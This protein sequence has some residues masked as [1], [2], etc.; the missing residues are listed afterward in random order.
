[1]LSDDSILVLTTREKSWWWSMQEVIPAVERIWTGIGQSGRENVR[2]LCVPL[3]PGIEQDLQT[4]ASQLKRI[5]I[6]A[7]TPETVKIAL[8]LRLQMKVDAPMIIYIFGDSTEGFHAFGALTDVLTEEDMF[9]VS[10][11]AEAAA[12]RCSFPNAEVSVIPIPLVDRFKMNGGDR[13]T[14]LKDARLAYVGRVSEQKNLHTLLFALWILHT[15]HG[16]LPKIT[17]E[18]YGGEDN[19]GS[20]NMGLK[21]P[22]YGMYLQGLTELLGLDRMVTWHG[23][24]SR[25]WLFDNV[26]LE[27]HILVSPTL[28][29]DENFGS[30]VLASLVNG[31]QVVTTAW[32]GHFG[33]Q[34]W[35]SRQLI[36][37][38]VRRSTMGPVVDPFLLA[39]AILR[40]INRM[41]TVAVRDASLDQV[42]AEFS[43]SRVTARTLEIFSRTGGKSVPLKRSTIQHD[44]DERRNLFGGTRKI[45]ENYEDPIAQIFFEAYGMKE[46]LTFQEQS[47]YILPP[48]MSY[49]DNVL[50]I[51]DP[52]RG[53]Q[54][55]SLDAR[56]SKPLDVTM[57]PSMKTCRLP[58]S[59]VKSLV[60]QG[61]AFLLPPPDE[62]K[63]KEVLEG[64]I[65]E[66][67][68]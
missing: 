64:G 25:D 46:P 29:S 22:N 59:L 9:V 61:Y 7:V 23:F 24:K 5:V 56:I 40:A 36:L 21:F 41:S 66:P 58:E 4:S 48:W 44:I 50:R 51:V 8:L 12:T 11:E 32:G 10:S 47:S 45:Y 18:V 65:S 68:R 2:M 67:N 54:T 62:A 49:S 43:E 34:E 31:H 17:L 15:S 28:H 39:N 3:A 33:F 19:L 6:T 20:P 26:H 16:R 27:P 30:S 13:D 37:V 63:V 52:H 1:M 42:R 53:N 55:F 14:R 38:P 60:V 57:F 35:F